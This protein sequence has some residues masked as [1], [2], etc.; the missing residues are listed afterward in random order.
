MIL[1]V[2]TPAIPRS[3]L[4][5]KCIKTMIEE[6][7]KCNHFSEI[8]WFINIDAI[9]TS[10]TPK[11]PYIWENSEITKQNF[12]NISNGL[13][14]TSLKINISD[15]PCFYLAFRHLTLSV[16]EDINNSKL[17]DSEYCVM[18]LEDDWT[19]IDSEMFKN[20]LTKFLSEEQYLAYILHGKNGK[21]SSYPGKINMGGNPDIIKGRIFELFK[22]INLEKTNKRDPENIRKHDIWYPNV[23]I[24]PWGHELEGPPYNLLLKKLIAIN[25]NPNH[26]GRKLQKNTLSVNVVE[27]EQGDIWR[28]NL[29]VN[30]TFKGKDKHGIPADKSY[31]YQ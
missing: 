9:K 14:N 6:L 3:E 1:Y 26:E 13:S 17:K 31:S 23:F 11:G 4:H 27:G 19:F 18:W 5:N 24:D 12:I 7:D 2:Q 29:M 10:K 20:L 22:Y 25:D 28:A 21:P 30:K 16:L 8:R 15:N